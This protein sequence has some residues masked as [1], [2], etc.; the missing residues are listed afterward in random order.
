LELKSGPGQNIMEKAGIPVCGG[1][2]IPSARIAASVLTACYLQHER[3]YR[4]IYVY[5][6][7]DI[8]RG[9]E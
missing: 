3:I 8:G 6:Y 4:P 1:H 5:I 9:S 7:I 2:Q